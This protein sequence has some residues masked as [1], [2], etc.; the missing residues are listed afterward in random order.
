MTL[1]LYSHVSMNVFNSS[2][3]CRDG[4]FVAA[5]LER[6]DPTLLV[7]LQAQSHDVGEVVDL[8][9]GQILPLMSASWTS[10]L[11]NDSVS[12]R[13]MAKMTH[14]SRPHSRSCPCV[15]G[16]QQQIMQETSKPSRGDKQIYNQVLRSCSRAV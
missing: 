9:S 1:Y 11:T 7:H 12:L 13:W 10:P 5:R 16:G 14:V 3:V 2:T 4:D 15:D 6:P 8:R